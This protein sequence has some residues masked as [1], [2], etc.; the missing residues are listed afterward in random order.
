MSEPTPLK[1]PNCGSIMRAEDWD[2]ASGI[3]KCSYC[4]ALATLPRAEGENA[5]SSA[6]QARGEIPMPPGITVED[7]GGGILITRR[8]FSPVVFFLIPFCIAWDSFLVFWYSMA[9]KGPAPWIMV[10]FPVAHV[11][12]GVGLTYFCIATLLNRTF[13]SAGQGLLSI[14]HGPVPWRGRLVISEGDID[15]LFCKMKTSNGSRGT[16]YSYEVWTVL[17]D[18]ASRRLLDSGDSDD[19]ALFIEQKLERAL[20]IKDRAVPGE[21]PR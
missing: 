9:F 4:K 2:A 19:V 15:Q 10:V 21:L 18:G 11:A 17:R 6:F 13:I 7:R 8:W 5:T 20:G 14:T 1:C 3:I 12:V 16:S